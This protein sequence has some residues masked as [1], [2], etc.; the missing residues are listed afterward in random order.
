MHP[1]HF[2]R[3]LQVR[4]KLITKLAEIIDM[5]VVPSQFDLLR[6]TMQATNTR[7][8]VISQNLANVNTPGYHA[9]Q[10]NFEQ[11]LKELMEGGDHLGSSD[12]QPE[13]VEAVGSI[14]KENGNTVDVDN[15]LTQLNKNAMVHGALTQILAQK[16][17]MMQTAITGR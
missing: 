13:I 16:I 11:Q 3:P 8:K 12:L 4:L 17:A 14:E 7:H 6:Q 15:E 5:S 2:D 10:V 1:A 9:Q